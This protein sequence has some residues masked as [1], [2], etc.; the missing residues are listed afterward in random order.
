[1]T[2]DMSATT[3]CT[4]HDYELDGEFTDLSLADDC[5][6]TAY[7]SHDTCTECGEHRVQLELYG[8]GTHLDAHFTTDQALD[9]AAWL[10]EAAFQVLDARGSRTGAGREEWR[11]MLADDERR[12]RAFP[13]ESP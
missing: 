4:Q 13:E 10:N 1:M 7:V 6:V 2:T 9:V 3:Q 12:T 5:G 11:R 8:G